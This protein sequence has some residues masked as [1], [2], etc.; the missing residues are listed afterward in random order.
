[1]GLGAA[2][3]SAAAVTHR[4]LSLERSPNS[5]TGHTISVPPRCPR[6]SSSSSSPSPAAAAAAA[7]P[8]QRL[9]ASA[10]LT[11]SASVSTVFPSPISSAK[12]PPVLA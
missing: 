6:S 11:T 2:R 3:A 12:M 1:M 9:F 8:R 7:S 4:L 5:D 10:E